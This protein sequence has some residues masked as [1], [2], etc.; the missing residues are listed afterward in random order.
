MSRIV[1]NMFWLLVA[2]VVEK[3]LA[4][5]LVVLVTRSL[6]SIGYGK[7]SFAFAF[8]AVFSILANMGLVTYLLKEVSKLRGD[9]EKISGLVS[10]VSTL[11]M[12]LS[13]G[14]LTLG[15]IS[16]LFVVKDAQMKIVLLLA[17]MQEIM[18]AGHGLTRRVMIAYERNELKAIATTLEKG[19][20]L[21]FAALSFFLG[22]GLVGLFA[23]LFVGKALSLLISG[24]M[25]QVSCVRFRPLFRLEH[26]KGILQRSFPYWLSLVSITLYYQVD[27]IM[28]A[29]MK[30]YESTGL[31]G[32]ASAITGALIF[33]PIIFI[34][35]SFPTMS[36]HHAQEDRKSLQAVYGLLVKYLAYLAMPLTVGLM[37][38]APRVIQFV[39]K[40]E[41]LA[42][43]ILLRVLSVVLIL[44]YMNYLMGYLLN[45]IDRQRQYSAANVASTILNIAANLVL[46]PSLAAMGAAL[47]TVFSQGVAFAMLVFYTRRAGYH[48]LIIRESLKPLLCAIGMGMVLWWMREFSLFLTVP[49]GI[50]V[51]GAL[52]FAVGGVGRKELVFLKESFLRR[53]APPDVSQENNR[54]E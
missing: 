43:V 27:K 40:E 38:L 17:C 9:Q 24:I 52:L 19:L 34:Y 18:T 46:I 36:R 16:A 48:T 11:G 5:L 2:D 10:E 39:Y 33:V 14:F 22:Y 31:Y 29:A 13:S 41:F 26:A 4:F 50:L 47:A 35:A 21:A 23:A 1:R 25:T 3:L 28:L 20:P 30:G 32:A 44:L 42:S 45:A 51:Y 12:L 53:S 8:V 6:G 49:L 15:F 37:L 54:V 7:Y